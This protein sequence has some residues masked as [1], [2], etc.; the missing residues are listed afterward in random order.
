MTPTRIAP[1]LH[2]N[3][4]PND[5]CYD[6]SNGGIVDGD[7]VEEIHRHLAALGYDGARLEVRDEAG[8][9]RGYADGSDWRAR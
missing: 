7:T 4:D 8:F 9:V 2:V 5:P 3:I 1:A 6:E